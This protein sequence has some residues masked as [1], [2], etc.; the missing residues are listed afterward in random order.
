MDLSIATGEVIA[1]LFPR[2][3]QH[4]VEP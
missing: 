3:G 2:F 4:A 1:Q